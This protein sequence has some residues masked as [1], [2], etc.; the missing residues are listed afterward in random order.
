MSRDE[1]KDKES[2]LKQND[3]AIVKSL[4]PPPSVPA[5]IARGVEKGFH[6]LTVAQLKQVLASRGELQT[7][8]KDALVARA[9]G[10]EWP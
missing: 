9:S 6:K 10:L 8:N 2:Y 1:E 7:G 5:L 3:R 4:I